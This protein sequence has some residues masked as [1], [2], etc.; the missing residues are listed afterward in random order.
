MIAAAV[1]AGRLA[2]RRTPSAGSAMPLCSTGEAPQ[3]MAVTHWRHLAPQNT[4]EAHATAPADW[5][6][7]CMVQGALSC[8][9]V[10]HFAQRCCVLFQLLMLA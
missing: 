7:A 4:W 8:P 9:A 1:K 5:E 3:H 10:A 6:A 2:I